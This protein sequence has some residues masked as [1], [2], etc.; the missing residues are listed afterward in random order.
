M[1]KERTYSFLAD[2]EKLCDFQNLFLGFSRKADEAAKVYWH[3][4][5]AGMLLTGQVQTE[6]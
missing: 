5:F 1:Q 6:Q 3:R 4:R 2:P